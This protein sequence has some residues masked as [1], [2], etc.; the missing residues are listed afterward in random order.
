MEVHCYHVYNVGVSS[1][2]F[3]LCP[4][5][6]PVFHPGTASLVQIALFIQIQDKHLSSPGH[7]NETPPAVTVIKL[8]LTSAPGWLVIR[9]AVTYTAAPSVIGVC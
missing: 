7:L 2:L 9:L 8:R 5:L 1:S 4:H 6:A 3:S